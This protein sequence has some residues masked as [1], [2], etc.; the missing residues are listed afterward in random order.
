RSVKG[1]FLVGSDETIG[2]VKEKS[3]SFFG[4]TG[5]ISDENPGVIPP[6]SKVDS[7]V[8]VGSDF[9]NKDATSSSSFV[10]GA[11]GTSPSSTPCKSSKRTK[12]LEGLFSSI[13]CGKTE[14][15]VFSKTPP[16]PLA[17]GIPFRLLSFISYII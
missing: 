5:G 12:L 13:S 3:S 17:I 4:V 10:P 9:G 6:T 15:P 2:V 1:S 7:G 14:L 11:I 16:P 8:G